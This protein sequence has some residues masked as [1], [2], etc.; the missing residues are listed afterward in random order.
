M[1]Y[2][3]RRSEASG[4]I[5]GI[6]LN[7]TKIESFAQNSYSLRTLDRCP[8]AMNGEDIDQS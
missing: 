7:Q 8:W 4:G 5:V 3:G 1:G 2:S 6:T